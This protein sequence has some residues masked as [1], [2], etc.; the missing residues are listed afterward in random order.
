MLRDNKASAIFLSG[1]IHIA[2]IMEHPCGKMRVGKIYAT[3][4][5]M[6]LKKS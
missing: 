2:E 1:D 5:D 4:R 3:I 6:G